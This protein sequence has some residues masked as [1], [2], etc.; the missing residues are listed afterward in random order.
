[1]RKHSA[2]SAL[3]PNSMQSGAAGPL[4]GSTEDPNPQKSRRLGVTGVRLVQHQQAKLHSLK[5]IDSGGTSTSPSHAG[6]STDARITGIRSWRR[7]VRARARRHNREGAPCRAAVGG[8]SLPTRPQT[9]DAPRPC[10][11]WPRVASRLTW[12]SIRRMH[13]PERCSAGLLVSRGT[14]LTCLPSLTAC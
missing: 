1:M 7:H 10:G 5:Q 2:K 3:Q 4:S 12:P 6:Q 11:R 9:P 8:A 13:R 14:C